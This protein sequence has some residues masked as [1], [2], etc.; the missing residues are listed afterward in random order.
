MAAPLRL[1]IVDDDLVDRRAVT[2][3]LAQAGVAA[4]IVEAGD[5]DGALAAVERERFDCVLLDYRLP[6]ADG[7]AL[8]RDLRDRS[9]DLA[10]VA[11]TGQGDQ[12]LAVELMKAGAADFLD[13][14]TLTAERLERS[15]RQQTNRF[16]LAMGAMFTI[17]TTA[18]ALIAG[19]VGG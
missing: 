2:R 16:L 18:Q 19:L 11:L 8:L 1:L 5:R 15:L 17:A 13:K 6:G 4:E 14:N 10:V 3:L 12:E 7:A 9:L